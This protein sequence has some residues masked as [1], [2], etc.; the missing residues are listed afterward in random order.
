MPAHLLICPLCQSALTLSAKNWHCALGHN[1]DLAREGYAN[2][3]VVQHKK[4]KAPGDSQDMVDARTRVLESG[5][6]QPIS[7][8]INQWVQ[9]ASLPLANAQI[10][11]IGCG[12]GYYTERLE[13]SLQAQ[14]TSHVLYAVDIAKEAIKR[15]AKRSKSIYWLVASGGRLPLQAQGLDIIVN[16]FT[17]PMPQGFRQALKKGGQVFI[18]STGAQHLMELRQRIYD[19][20]RLDS[21]NPQENMQQQGFSLRQEQRLSYAVTLNSPAQIQD[22]LFMTPHRYKIRPQAL[23]AL[24]QLSTLT[25]RVEVLVQQFSLDASCEDILP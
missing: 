15:A 19:E 14:G 25:V 12:E 4:S 2:L 21:Y 6:Y 3:L 13:R 16:L 22:L 10:A 7:D 11:D 8:L 24:Q 1:F 18:V 17:N 20:V 5:I 9:A 23:E